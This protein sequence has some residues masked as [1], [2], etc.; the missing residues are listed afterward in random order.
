MF[1][2][3]RSGEYSDF[4]V[5]QTSAPSSQSTDYSNFKKEWRLHVFMCT[6]YLKL[7]E[8]GC[9]YAYVNCSGNHDRVHE[10]HEK[11]EFTLKRKMDAYKLC[12]QILSVVK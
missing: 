8:D 6:Q 2:F 11:N 12:K 9:T 7:F 1:G 5:Y 3:Y 10:P 4:K